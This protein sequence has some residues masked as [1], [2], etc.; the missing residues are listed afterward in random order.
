M[1]YAF[2]H[3]RLDCYQLAVEV[4]RFI[5]QASFP[6]GRS[7]LRD[8]G[9]RA[10]DSVVLNLA[11]GLGRTGK[12]KQNHLSIARAAAAE[13]CAVLDLATVKHGVEHQQKLRRV[14]AMLTKL[15]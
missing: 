4:N 11:E 10:S 9:L 2:H 6:A 15:R 5:A 14:A 12:A 7:H 13:C 1:K 8:Q 3:E